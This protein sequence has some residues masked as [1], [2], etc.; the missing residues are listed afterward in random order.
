MIRTCE[1]SRPCGATPVLLVT[2]PQ[3]VAGP[4]LAVC[5]NHG[6]LAI[7]RVLQEITPVEWCRVRTIGGVVIASNDEPVP[8]DHGIGS[9]AGDG[10]DDHRSVA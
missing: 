10:F 5:G 7:R 2:P 8:S 4:S 1:G 9:V 3:G 6:T